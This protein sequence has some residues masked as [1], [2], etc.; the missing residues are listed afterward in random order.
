VSN[1]E[2]RKQI[3]SNLNLKETDELLDLW[4]TNHRGEWS[5]EA[6]K[7][8]QDI[9]IERSVEVPEQNKPVYEVEEEPV[10]KETLDNEGLEEWEAKLLDNANQPEFYDTLE[11]ITLKDN[12]NKVAKAVIVIYA[13]QS[14][15][16]FQWA[17][18][19]VASYFLDRQTFMP[20]IYL[21]SFLFTALGAAVSI[22]IVYFPL[23]ALTH[24]LR[25][26][27]EMEFRSRKAI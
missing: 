6:F 14:I 15:P 5:D 18:Q 19:L 7:V 2:L 9:L 27:M 24:I 17:S 26:L 1:E 11:V 13:L 21:I 12:I 22:A 25:I 3:Y 16:T 8:I 4:Q 10:D 20:L 23:K